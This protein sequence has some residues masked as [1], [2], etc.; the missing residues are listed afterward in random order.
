M[1]MEVWIWC[2]IIDNIYEIVAMVRLDVVQGRCL[3]R[4]LM[5]LLVDW[6]SKWRWVRGVAVD[7]CRM[8]LCIRWLVPMQRRVRIDNQREL[9]LVFCCWARAPLLLQ[10]VSSS[11]VLLQERTWWLWFLLSSWIYLQRLA[12]VLQQQHSLLTNNWFIYFFFPP[13]VPR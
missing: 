1:P 2:R 4:T 11:V 9:W 13:C 7:P 5:Q 12:W 6:N 10:V 3:C 8:R